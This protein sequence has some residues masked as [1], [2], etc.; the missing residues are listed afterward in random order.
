LQKYWRLSE[1]RR[2]LTWSLRWVLAQ[3]SRRAAQALP[4]GALAA[5]PRRRHA[6]RQGIPRQGCQNSRSPHPGVSSLIADRLALARRCA[7]PDQQDHAAASPSP[8]SHL[9]SPRLLPTTPPAMQHRLL[10]TCLTG[11]RQVL[12]ELTRPDTAGA[13]RDAHAGTLEWR[14]MASAPSACSSQAGHQRLVGRPACSP[15]NPSS[16]CLVT[17]RRECGCRGCQRAALPWERCAAGKPCQPWCPACPATR[18]QL[19]F[20]RERQCILYIVCER[21]TRHV[22]QV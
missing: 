18:P 5:A 20:S 13:G 11:G 19:H 8:P 3:R 16:S 1:W 2:R 17:G 9:P 14:W 12:S 7:H 6:C 21:T 4:T 10:P 15:C 22:S